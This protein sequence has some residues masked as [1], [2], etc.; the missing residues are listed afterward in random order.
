MSGNLTVDEI[1]AKWAAHV[2]KQMVTV[3]NSKEPGYTDVYR[4]AAFPTIDADIDMHAHMKEVFEKH[5]NDRCVG[6]RPWDEKKGDLADHF[7]W[8]TYAQAGAESDALGSA[9]TKYVDEG[10]LHPRPANGIATSTPGRTQFTTAYWGP[11]RPEAAIIGMSNLAYGRV[12]V[13]LYDNYDAAVS[14]FILQHCHARVL[15]TTTHYVPNVLRTADKLPEL[16]LI[17]LLDLPGPKALPLFELQRSQL[18]REWA[19]SHDIN[20]MTYDEALAYGKANP[21]PHMPA[22]IDEIESFCYTSGTTGLPK[23]VVIRIRNVAFGFLGIRFLIPEEGLVSISYLPLAHVL[24]RGWESFILSRGGA[25]GYYSGRIDRL[26]ED[27]KLLKPNAMPTV[28]RVLNRIAAQIE[29]Q[30]AEGGLKASLLT[31]ALN[32]K[33]KNYEETGTITHAFWDRLIFRKVRANLGGNLKIMITGSA[34]C[35][36]DVLRLLRVALVVDIREGYGQTENCAYATFMVPNDRYVGCVG[37][38]NPGLELRL[39]DC[40]ELGYK[41]SDAPFPRGEIEIRG[42]SVFSDY[43]GDEKKTKETFDG[44][45]LATG[46]IGQIDSR[47]RL[48]IID[49]VKNLIKLAQGEY[50]AIERVEGIFASLP[51][52]QQVWLYGDSFQPHLVAV[53]VPEPEPFAQFASK[54]LGRKISPSDTTAL[55]A[56]AANPSVVEAVLRQFIALGKSQKLGTLEQMRALKLRIEPFTP[57]NGLL[58]PTLKVKRQEA[59]KVLRS[60]LDDLYKMTPYDLNKVK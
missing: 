57:D 15:Y 45:W 22:G 21:Y 2:N 52:C 54:V 43:Y 20:V 11:N 47:G 49:R 40:P 41:A 1:Y 14:C 27:L 26:L 3:P 60:E 23:A 58:T 38:V 25:I 17:I 6:H 18:V 32:T 16:R 33:I 29:S 53:A 44:D 35:R 28:P 4:S 7:E 24:E 42:G 5:A 55:E 56:A 36:K 13:S 10:A 30:I 50:I 59:A 9:L 34:P 37:P 51:L 19:K 12:S 31:T 48:M 8:R 39:R 46:D